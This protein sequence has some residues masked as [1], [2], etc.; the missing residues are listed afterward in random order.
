MTQR[1]MRSQEYSETESAHGRLDLEQ[2]TVF[3]VFN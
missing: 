3:I 1:R 2:Q